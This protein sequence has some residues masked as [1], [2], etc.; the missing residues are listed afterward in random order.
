MHPPE[1][2]GIIMTITILVIVTGVNTLIILFA[3]IDGLLKRKYLYPLKKQRTSE[4]ILTITC[5][6]LQTV[7]SLNDG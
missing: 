5:F 4:T 1:R 7:V 2:V 3:D 6:I